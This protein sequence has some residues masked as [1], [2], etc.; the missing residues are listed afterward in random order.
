MPIRRAV[1]LQV[2]ST[3]TRTRTT[4]RPCMTDNRHVV[5]VC[6]FNAVANWCCWSADVGPDVG[7]VD[8][9]DAHLPQELAAVDSAWR[10]AS[11]I[12]AA[13]VTGVGGHCIM[14]ITVKYR[15]TT[16]R[17]R[18]RLRF[19]QQLDIRRELLFYSSRTL[20]IYLIDGLCKHR[21]W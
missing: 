21:R 20:V 11:K 5:D 14:H 2:C 6:L 7:P 16:V 18:L 10:L 12:R 1:C 15:F 4:P 13:C 3:K 19:L 8:A 17:S 9:I